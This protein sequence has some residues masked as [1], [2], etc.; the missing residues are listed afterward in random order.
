MKKL[1]AAMVAAVLFLAT[2]SISIPAAEIKLGK[3]G[4]LT[5][6]LTKAETE[7]CK[8]E[9][10]CYVLSGKTL[11]EVVDQVRSECPA[12]FNVPPKS[13]KKEI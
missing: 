4:Q 11:G 10:G 9:G 7:K 13:D 3:N 5:V 2:L 1:K 12:N 6:T 8:T